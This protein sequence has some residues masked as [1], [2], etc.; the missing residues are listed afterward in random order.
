M[1]KETQREPEAW[2]GGPARNA[3]CPCGSGKKY[4]HCC[5]AR[6]DAAVPG[7]NGSPSD[8]HAAQKQFR[9]GVQL[10]KSG[11]MSAAM[12]VLLKAMQLDPNHF[13]A[14][15]ALG[16]ALMRS[17][18]FA[19]A[20]VI[21]TRAVALRPGSAAAWHDLGTSCDRQNL[22]QQAI[23]AY[24]RA[25]ELEPKLGDVLCRLAELYT[26]YGRMDEAS[27]CFE[28]AADL[29][30][31]TAKARLFRSDARLLRGDIS[32]AEEWARKA[33][34]REP[35]SDS[36]H[37]TLAGL[38]YAQGRFAEAAASFEAAL[39]LNPK[40]ARCWYGLAECRQFSEADNSILDRMRAVLQRHDL[41]DFE[42]MLVHFA[43]GKVYDGCDD[44]AHA[45]EQFDAANRLR[46]RD[47]KF[48]RAAFGALVARNIRQFTQ[49]FIASGA[50][51]GTRDEKPLFIVGMYRSGTTMVEQI[52]SSHPEIA[53]GGELTVWTPTDIEIDPAT[54][55]FDPAR[56]HAAIQKY[57]SV[58]QRIGP[59][60]A[61][62]T[63]KLPF[64]CFRLGAIHSLMPN[65]RII[66]CRRDP[67][68][69]C[70]SI[71]SN[72]FKGRV[73]FAAKKDDLAFCYQQYLRMMDH[74]RKVLPAEVF[75]E[76]EYER[77]IAGRE[78]ETRRLIAFT[79]LD[80][81]DSCL[82]PEQNIRAI[83]TASAWQVR[84]PV[85]TTS[86]QRWRHYAPWLGELRQLLS[87][88]ACHGT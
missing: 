76:V 30:P 12:P 8:P 64:N 5:G 38:L 58:L 11:Q 65:A 41:S 17:G 18:R 48:D 34:A 59:S 20:S 28:R 63:D 67:V 53:A 68:D 36:A 86:S 23:E 61:R 4:K 14:H 27:D 78:V 83:D 80:W 21:L 32:G 31:E 7:S 16:S 46:A 74:W 49:E 47:L 85:Y 51:S 6:S 56:A 73:D 39:R 81:N 15:H 69:T 13:E 54:G 1:T 22:H 10:L 77:L 79:G 37:G 25:V 40:S 35:A 3:L 72:L 26:M 70:L 62:V 84:Q 57:L 66:H 71:Y 2:P 24:R 60:A 42:R 82:K 33:V 75:L 43:M 87:S 9:R 50:A 52:V 19:D 55:E 29:D 44:Y 88:E 45:M